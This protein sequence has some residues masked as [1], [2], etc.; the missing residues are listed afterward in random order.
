MIFSGA[1]LPRERPYIASTTVTTPLRG[2]IFFGYLKDGCIILKS[3]GKTLWLTGFAVCQILS[4]MLLFKASQSIPMGTAYVVWTGIGA[5]GTVTVGI[6]VYKEP[7]VFLRLVFL[8]LAVVSVA[9][10]KNGIRLT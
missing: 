3:V 5:V 2:T 9:G 1:F 4:M 6:L 8:G 7:H 10:L